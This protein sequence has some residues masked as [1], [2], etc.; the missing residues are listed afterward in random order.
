MI[1]AV[2]F[3]MDGVLID[4]RDWHYE[5]LNRALEK[6]GMAIDRDTHLAAYDGLPTRKKLAMLTK[7]RG[8]PQGLHEFLN[9]LKQRYTLEIAHALCKPTFAHQR[10][11]SKLKA[12]GMKIA[13]CSNSVRDT[14]QLMMKLA[15]LEEYLDLM[16]SNE[17][18]ARP[19]PDPDMYETAMRKL[20]LAPSECLIIEDNDHGVEAARASGGAV[21]IVASPAEVTYESIA[22]RIASLKAAASAA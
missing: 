16:L 3:D 5:A 20:G 11:L 21:L 19:K 1:K 8:L 12:D 13:V 4:A 15:K 18:V 17:D 2:L 22:N 10:A 7:S 6:F 9:A 14:V